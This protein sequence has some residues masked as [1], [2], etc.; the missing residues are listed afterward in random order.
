MVVIR[1]RFF[2][3]WGSHPASLYRILYLCL[4]DIPSLIHPFA[5]YIIYVLQLHTHKV[6]PVSL[7]GG[8]SFIYSSLLKHPSSTLTPLSLLFMAL[9]AVQYAVQP[10]LSKKYISPSV[11]KQSVALVEEVVKTGMAAAIFWSKPADIVKSE[12]QGTVQSPTYTQTCTDRER[13]RERRT[14]QCGIDEKGS[15]S[16]SCVL[17]LPLDSLLT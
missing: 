7:I 16:S 13:E 3:L 4:S 17:L 5:M 8:T 2:P 1:F 10:R 12:L 11:D 9:L 15:T 14:V 6:A